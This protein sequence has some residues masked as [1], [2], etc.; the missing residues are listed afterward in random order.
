MEKKLNE[1]LSQQQ[2]QKNYIIDYVRLDAFMFAYTPTYAHILRI[3]G[4]FSHWSCLIKDLSS[5][6]NLE[7]WNELLG[8]EAKKFSLVFQKNDRY[9]IHFVIDPI[10]YSITHDLFNGIKWVLMR[11]SLIVICTPSTI[12]E[13]YIHN[14]YFVGLITFIF[15]QIVPRSVPSVSYW[16][17]EW[18]LSL[19]CLALCLDHLNNSF[20][21]HIDIEHEQQTG[22]AKAHR[23]ET[24]RAEKRNVRA[25]CVRCARVE[26]LP[27]ILASMNLNKNRNLPRNDRAQTHPYAH[28][29]AHANAESLWL[30]LSSFLRYS[31]LCACASGCL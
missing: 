23:T 30:P 5:L 20:K 15:G 25:K 26:N 2:Q 18:F 1:I 19:K 29:H 21:W 24:N 22:T 13:R 3:N 11:V 16:T 27:I 28:I 8:I 7:T 17:G 4:L 10:L 6:L 12:Y 9:A 31:S 14:T